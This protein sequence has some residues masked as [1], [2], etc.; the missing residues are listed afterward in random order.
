MTLSA[1]LPILARML[2]DSWKGCSP[3]QIPLNIFLIYILLF[4]ESGDFGDLKN[5][6]NRYVIVVLFSNYSV[7][8]NRFSIEVS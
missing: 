5:C 7:G 3:F 2:G 4:N 8:E 6:R 1:C